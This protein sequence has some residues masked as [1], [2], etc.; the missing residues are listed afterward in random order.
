MDIPNEFVCQKCG[1]CCE[2]LGE[3]VA[4]HF[5]KVDS[6]VCPE[7]DRGKRLCNIYENR[8]LCCGSQIFFGDQ[9]QIDTCRLLR[10]IRKWGTRV[11]SER[12]KRIIAVLV[13]AYFG[14]SEEQVEYAKS[15]LK[16]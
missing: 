13:P 5:L 3:M 12:V 10:A 16:V 9:Y 15:S 11:D 8:P 6:D 14:A 4:R 1:A 2:L 7:Y